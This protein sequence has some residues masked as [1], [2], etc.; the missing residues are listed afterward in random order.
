MSGWRV[1]GLLM[2]AI[3]LLAAALAPWITH[4]APNDLHLYDVLVPPGSKFWLGT[5]GL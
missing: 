2:V 5:D 3:V 1:A 4:F